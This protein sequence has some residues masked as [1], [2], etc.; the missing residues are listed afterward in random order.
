[1]PI[2]ANRNAKHSETPILTKH[3]NLARMRELVLQLQRVCP[4][5]ELGSTRAP[6][7]IHVGMGIKKACA[8]VLGTNLVEVIKSCSCDQFQSFEKNQKLASGFGLPANV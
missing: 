2:N 1:M 5:R 6:L 4:M 3:K 7:Q 8:S